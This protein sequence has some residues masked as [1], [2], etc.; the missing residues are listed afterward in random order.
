MET[1]RELVWV[2]TTKDDLKGFPKPVQRA[3]GFALYRVQQGRTPAAAKPL[4]GFGG[5]GVLELVDDFDGDTYRTVY[6]VRLAT[7]VYV[8]H[9]FQKKATRGIVTPRRELELVRSRL[10]QA[11]AIDAE[12]RRQRL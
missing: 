9:A 7:A 2:G 4:K 5:A 3:M 12:R 8:L 1:L 10:R 11:E 6:T